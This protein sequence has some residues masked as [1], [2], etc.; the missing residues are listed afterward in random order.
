MPD[1]NNTFRFNILGFPMQARLYSDG[2]SI[3]FN[4]QSPVS[5]RL[6][7]I[8]NNLT[9]P[10][11]YVKTLCVIFVISA[12]L[13]H[14]YSQETNARETTL[15]QRNFFAE[16]RPFSTTSTNLTPPSCVKNEYNIVKALL[17]LSMFL[18]FG[19]ISFFFFLYTTLRDIFQD[20]IDLMTNEITQENEEETPPLDLSYLDEPYNCQIQKLIDKCE[21]FGISLDDAPNEFFCFF[22]QEI[23]REP[24][25]IVT[26]R[27]KTAYEKRHI[28]MWVKTKNTCPITK[29]EV[30][31]KN[32]EHMPE[33]EAEIMNYLENLIFDYNKQQIPSK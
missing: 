7:N 31:L 3:S 2:I 15:S 25:K 23:I 18:V 30:N 9:D 8:P 26:S 1:L 10:R 24:A 16:Q 13:S 14:T 27:A 29:E 5:I 12:I 32:I 4:N 28:E 17:S 11:N 6:S 19:N 21:L 22:T 33:L 20:Q